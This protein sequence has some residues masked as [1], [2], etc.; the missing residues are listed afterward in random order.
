MS[1][2]FSVE[3]QGDLSRADV[4]NI[5]LRIADVYGTFVGTGP[6]DSVVDPRDSDGNSIKDPTYF[7]RSSIS[8]LRSVGA[9]AAFNYP[10]PFN[11]GKQPTSIV[12]YAPNT[13]AVTV[14]IFTITGK[15]VRTLTGQ[16]TTTGSN[17]IVWDGKNG[18]GQTVR[19][20]VYVAVILP[21]GGDRQMVKIA[22]VK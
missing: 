15:L 13:G 9:D 18:R 14:K 21:P 2:R 20:G 16:V 17:E 1:L 5:R 22:V 4:P 3:V 8:N 10:N 11:P 19:N 6:P 7:L 12:Y